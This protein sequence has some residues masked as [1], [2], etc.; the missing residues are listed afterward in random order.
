[1]ERKT[2]FSGTAPS[3]MLTIGNYIGAFKQWLRFQDEYESLFC[4]VDLH[5]LTSP[6]DPATLRARTLDFFA[7]FIACGLDPEKCTVFVQSHN[8][9]HTEM[10]WILNGCT[11]YGELTRM[12]QFKDKASRSR[13]VTAGLLNYPILMAADILLYATSL[14]PVG[15][16]QRQHVELTREI[17]QRFNATFGTTLAIPEAF[18]P[19]DG[20]RIRSLLDPV[21]KMD[22]SDPNPRTYISL[23]DSAEEVRAKIQKAK[24][25]SLG[26]FPIHDES[27]GIANLV[28]IYASL[29]GG[30][31]EGIV[32]RYQGRGYAPLKADL[33][34]C[35]IEF[36]RPIQGRYRGIRSDAGA[37][38]RIAEA[39]RTKAI[40]RSRQTMR[41]VREAVGLVP[42]GGA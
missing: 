23:L 35:I 6:Q 1:M 15:A 13:S 31:R 21:R 38:S 28:T 37:L 8:P 3:G 17:A 22:K 7:L 42:Y 32:A 41:D 34:E 5:A 14:V 9:F 12:T 27:E 36:L 2:L 4:I 20:A 40:E 39:G 18:I 29:T 19:E 33:S 16:D 30:S 24:T 10:A 11:S 25:D 26:T